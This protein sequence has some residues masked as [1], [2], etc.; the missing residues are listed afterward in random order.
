[1]TNQGIVRGNCT[2]N[3]K[4]YK[5]WGTD[6]NGRSTEHEDRWDRELLVARGTSPS[7]PVSSLKAYRVSH[8]LVHMGWVDFDCPT[9]CSI[10]P[11]L[12]GIWKNWLSKW[13]R[14]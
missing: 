3:F 11:R 10:L 1:M 14:W 12:M 5:I 4:K 9:V 8:L 6:G 7:L 2:G 13:A